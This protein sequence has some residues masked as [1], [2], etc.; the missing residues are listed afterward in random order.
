LAS[1]NNFDFYRK[2]CAGICIG[3]FTPIIWKLNMKQVVHDIALEVGGSHWPTVGG[4]L[5][6][7]SILTAVRQCMA[8]AI[9]NGAGLTAQAIAQHFGI[10]E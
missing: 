6:E 5:L 3:I 1:G 8:I 7:Q 2:H 10:D 9:Q 4:K